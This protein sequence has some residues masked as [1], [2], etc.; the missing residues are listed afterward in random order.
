MVILEG[1]ES[2]AG[3]EETFAPLEAA[4]PGFAD[5]QHVVVQV[6]K[7]GYGDRWPGHAVRAS[8]LAARSAI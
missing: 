8:T 4:E 3:A 1:G 7:V 5:P 2:G 6:V